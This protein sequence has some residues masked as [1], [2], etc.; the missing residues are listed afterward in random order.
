[1]QTLKYIKS[2]CY[3]LCAGKKCY[4]SRDEMY[5]KRKTDPTPNKNVARYGSRLRNAGIFLF[6][7]RK[8]SLLIFQSA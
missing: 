5:L 7:T 8:S 2:H 4:C 6:L 3:Q 1:M